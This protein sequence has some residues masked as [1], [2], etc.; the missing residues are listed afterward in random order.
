MA[1]KDIRRIRYFVL[2]LIAF[3][4]F[5]VI[6]V[7]ICFSQEPKPTLKINAAIDIPEINFEDGNLHQSAFH[8][9]L[10]TITDF[11]IVVFTPSEYANNIYDKDP[12]YSNGRYYI[13]RDFWSDGL[14]IDF[15]FGEWV[16][17]NDFLEYGVVIGIDIATSY[18]RHEL[19]VDLHPPLHRYWTADGSVTRVSVDEAA[20]YVAY[21]ESSIISAMR[22]HNLKELHLLKVKISR[23]LNLEKT[24]FWIL[25]IGIFLFSSVSVF[26]IRESSPKLYLMIVFPLIAYLSFLIQ[27]T[28]PT[29]VSIEWLT[30]IDIIVGLVLAGTVILIPFLHLG[31]AKG[32][33]SKES[34]SAQKDRMEG[35][36][37]D[38]EP[39]ENNKIDSSL[40][41]L[42]D[43]LLA[44]YSNEVC[45]HVEA[46][47]ALFFGLI[48]TLIV[49][50]IINTLAA[51]IIF[52]LVYFVLGGLGMYFFV[53]LF[54]Y[55]KMLEEILF[56]KQ[57]RVTHVK[58]QSRVLPKSKLINA[59]QWIS[60]YKKGG[61]RLQWAWVMLILAGLIAILAWLIIVLRL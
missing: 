48:G 11:G 30:V 41:L 29:M 13:T 36:D 21:G 24:V 40:P 49:I 53:R 39:S 60:R 12:N 14:N 59:T 19:Y 58:F 27:I 57:Y 8:L 55:R 52:S 5:L 26:R 50:E 44:H 3:W 42:Y 17:I 9:Y 4:I 16:F 10:S 43:N 54:Y 7:P 38:K 31:I 1:L 61:Y 34:D 32:T 51:R 23:K 37:E 22:N 6:F 33:Q 18:E 25:P 46:S 15:L 20:R 47:I 35:M 45:S 2:F 28:P 56:S